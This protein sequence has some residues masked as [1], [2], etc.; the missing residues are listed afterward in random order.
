MR[1]STSYWGNDLEAVRS[2]RWKLHF[3]HG[4]RTLAGRPGGS[5]GKPTQYEQAKTD[6]ALFDLKEDIAEKHNLAPEH[7]EV[8]RR[9]TEIS[10]QFDRELQRN[11][12]PAGRVSGEKAG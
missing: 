8:V 2:G 11:R 9:L 1:R 4:Y 7:P 10:E 12:R 6:V 5:G 3:R